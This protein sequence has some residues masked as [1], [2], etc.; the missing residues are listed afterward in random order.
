MTSHN[1]PPPPRPEPD[2]ATLADIAKLS[3][4]DR[5]I[6]DDVLEQHPAL[7]HK[8]ALRALKHAGL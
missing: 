7:S 2:A 6:L 1:D 5:K 3:P 8:E 4:R